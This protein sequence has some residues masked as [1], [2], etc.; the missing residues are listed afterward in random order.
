M[1]FIFFGNNFYSLIFN[2]LV[3]VILISVLEYITGFLLESLFNCRCW[4]YSHNAINL[5][6]Y[7]C[8]KF[9]LLWGILTIVLIKLVHPFVTLKVASISSSDKYLLTIIFLLYFLI[10]I[11]NSIYDAL[12]LSSVISNYSFALSHNKIIK[13]KRFFNAF[14]GLIFSYSKIINED[15]RS[16]I[17]DKVDKIKFEFRTRFF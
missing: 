14:P 11:I 5:R 8:L 9:S 2:L 15:I 17:N 13:Y 12:D 16:I 4:D 10:D 3:V 7:V 1:P 6:G